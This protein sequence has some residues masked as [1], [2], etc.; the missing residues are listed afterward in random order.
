MQTYS[1]PAFYDEPGIHRR[2]VTARAAVDEPNT[3]LEEPFVISFLGD[4]TGHDVLDLGCGN[5]A[6]GPRLLAAGARSYHGID[7]SHRMV[8]SAVATLAGTPGRIELA[9]LDTWQPEAASTVDTVLARMVLHYVADL[10]RLLAA[11][12]HAC[13]PAAQLVFSVEHPVVT[14]SYD[15]DW[16][17]D[18]PRA[19]IVR[20]Y[21]REGARS[22]PWL[23]SQVR[24]YHR[25]FETYLDLLG[26]NRLR[27][28]RFSEGRP[29]PSAF[30]EIGTYQRR[31]AVPMY[32]TFRAIA[33]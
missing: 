17:G 30:A 2:Y 24:K 12:R 29:L 25:T 33:E 28:D 18:V 3:T 5:A 27:L 16:D 22:C 6:I 20:D 14:C 31:N 1:G 23:G 9:D 15:G 11:I 19:W 10:D 8:A 32:A 7:G 13:R 4:V 26:R 21:Y